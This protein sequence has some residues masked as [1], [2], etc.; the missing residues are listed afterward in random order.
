VTGLHVEIASDRKNS[1][2]SSPRGYFDESAQTGIGTS[3][4]KPI[5][6]F[7]REKAIPLE[8][9]LA[10]ID[11]DK[12]HSLDGF[13]IFRIYIATDCHFDGPTK[14]GQRGSEQP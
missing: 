6:P 12:L 4:E 2:D 10:P 7:R 11:P 5:R 9:N 13:A 1:T 3:P 14:I 8:K